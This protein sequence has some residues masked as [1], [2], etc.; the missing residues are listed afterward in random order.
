MKRLSI[1]WYK[2]R[3]EYYKCFFYRMSLAMQA[4]SGGESEGK[5]Y[6]MDYYIIF[7]F[8]FLKCHRNLIVELR[9]KMYDKWDMLPF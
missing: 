2:T 7:E 9:T 1:R 3:K 4:K 6:I 5:D 8:A